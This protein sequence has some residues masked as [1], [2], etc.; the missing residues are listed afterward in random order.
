MGGLSQILWKAK[1]LTGRQP[2]GTNMKR[3]GFWQ[4]A[5]C[6]LCKDAD[7]DAKHVV[8][9]PRVTRVWPRAIQPLQEWLRQTR[10]DTDVSNVI[11]DGLTSFQ[12]GDTPAID[13]FSLPQDLSDASLE[14]DALGW[15]NFLDGFIT[16]SWGKIM[17][18]RFSAGGRRMTGKRWTCSLLRHLWRLS[19]ELWDH[20]NELAHEGRDSLTQQAIDE[21]NRELLAQFQRGR[22]GM[23]A[24]L[25]RHLFRGS[26]HRLLAKPTPLKRAWLYSI[27]AAR[28]RHLRRLHGDAAPLLESSRRIMR[29]WVQRP[30]WRSR[31]RSP[32]RRRRRHVNGPDQREPD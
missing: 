5:T 2:W 8:R 9:C 10:T 31:L 11:I 29:N 24:R 6:P 7:E 14:Q 19:R 32:V 27:I 3:W 18:A 23:P 21:L 1:H 30:T 13:R 17:Q 28:E 22:D 26:V 16:T 25:T 12:R 4:E 15:R 20:R